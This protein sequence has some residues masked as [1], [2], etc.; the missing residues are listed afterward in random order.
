VY[1][2]S[3]VGDT[4]SFPDVALAPLHALEA[5]HELAFVVDHVSVVLSPSSIVVSLAENESVGADGGVVTDMLTD[6][7][8]S[9]PSPVHV[10][11]YV[12]F[13]VGETDWLP[14]SAL[15]PL[16]LPDAAHEFAFVEDQDSV[17]L[18]PL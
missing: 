16:Q 17:A 8:A 4:L 2:A 14:E 9:P 1:V 12:A 11:M 7:S 15:L 5:V 3:T 13:D 6:S 18:S 10:S